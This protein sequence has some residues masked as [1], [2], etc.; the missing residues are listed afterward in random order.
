M[1]IGTGSKVR[2]LSVDMGEGKIITV[3]RANVEILD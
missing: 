3:P 1:E 2:V